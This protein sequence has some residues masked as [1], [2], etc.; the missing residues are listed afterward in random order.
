M[1]TYCSN[2]VTMA[3]PFITLSFDYKHKPCTMGRYVLWVWSYEADPPTMEQTA[4]QVCV[5]A[6]DTAHVR[7][8]RQSSCLAR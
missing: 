2:F 7:W 4:C 8:W 5:H 1:H 6:S 3:T